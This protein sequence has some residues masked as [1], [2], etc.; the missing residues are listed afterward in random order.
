LD[1]DQEGR[2]ITLY[3]VARHTA[4]TRRIERSNWDVGRVATAAGTSIQQIS[5]SYYEAFIRQN[6]DR[7]AMTFKKGVPYLSEKKQDEIDRGVER[8]EKMMEGFDEIG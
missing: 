7:W 8:W 3:S 2:T 5:T 6:P 1:K 4:I